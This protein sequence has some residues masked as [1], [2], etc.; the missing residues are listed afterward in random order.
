MTRYTVGEE[1]LV[2]HFTA[3]ANSITDRY[4]P[5]L[6][7]NEKVDIITIRNLVVKEHHKV[8]SE[9][10]D[11]NSEKTCD[12]FILEDT[13]SK[14]VAYNQYPRAI[15]G[16]TT[17]TA[18]RMF[19]YHIESVADIKEK[20]MEFRLL[21]DYMDV[22][23]EGIVDKSNSLSKPRKELFDRITEMVKNQFNKK[24]VKEAIHKDHPDITHYV[25]EDVEP[26][27]A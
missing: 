13:E 23:E 19:K 20:P 9:W 18:D 14:N 15:Y 7:N 10:A 22:L 6:F 8:H 25:L 27:T 1:L 24:L 5:L 3:K 2:I 4:L 16:Q 11:E 21:T 17:D 26:A 12:G